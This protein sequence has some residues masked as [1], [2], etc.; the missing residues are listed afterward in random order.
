MNKENLVVAGVVLAL[1]LPLLFGA[2]TDGGLIVGPQGD[3][4]D[5]GE[6]GLGGASGPEHF[7]LQLF[8]AG[9]MDGGL[10]VSTTTTGNSV[11]DLSNVL[12]RD[13][14]VR[15]LQ[16]NADEATIFTLPTV[17]SLAAFIPQLGSCFTQK[18]E[19]SG[20]SNL[21]IA[22]GTGMDLQEPNDAS[23][24]DVVINANGFADI[25]YCRTSASVMVVTV[26]ET[27]VAD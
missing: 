25:E 22:A 23:V 6:Q 27:S 15:Y 24:H 21:T 18:I 19:N 17:A 4:G 11:A 10:F 12:S 14:Y 20:D 5:K 16:I 13:G 1:V 7:G 9:H 8:Y 26:S 3:K 2:Y